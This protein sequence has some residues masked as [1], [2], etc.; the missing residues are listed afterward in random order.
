MMNGTLETWNIPEQDS[1]FLT[2][3]FLDVRAP[4]EYSEGHFP[5]SENIPLLNDEERALVGTTY[6]KKGQEAALE[7]G[8]KLVSGTVKDLRLQAWLHHLQQNP[9]RMILCFRGGLRSQTVQRWCADEGL[10]R[11]RVQGGYKA[12][13]QHLIKR[14]QEL[15]GSAKILILSGATGSGKTAGL[16]ELQQKNDNFQALD[17]E[18]LANHRGSAFGERPG[19]QPR[20]AQFENNL[21]CTWMKVNARNPESYLALEDESRS[22]GHVAIPDALFEKMRASEIVLIEENIEARAK[23]ILQEYILELE[24]PQRPAA[25][26][27]F[28]QSTKRIERKLGNARCSEILKDIESNRQ[29]LEA[30]LVWITKLLKWYYDPLYEASL[31]RRNPKIAFQGPR[32]EALEYL[33]QNCKL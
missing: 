24:E 10:H 19:G 28:K 9:K 2:F 23:H 26:E 21:V 25:F 18:S 14:T 8:H 13:R 4:V 1:E 3:E 32:T 16:K 6:K 33:A 7:M 22:I 20:Q 12:V 30:N 15:A 29:N 11:P 5:S 17:L 27:S 31:K